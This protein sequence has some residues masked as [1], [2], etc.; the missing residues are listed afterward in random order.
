MQIF[1]NGA[2]GEIN[3]ATG[4]FT[5]DVVG[6]ITLNA[7]GSYVM[8]N[9]DTINF[10]QFYQNASGN[11]NIQ[12]PTQDKDIIFKGNDGG[13][14]ITALTLDMSDNGTAKFNSYLKVSSYE[15]ELAG[16]HLRFKF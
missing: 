15:T 14:T 16:G 4:S 10:A 8:F 6:N 2:N 12:A 11:L 13:S 5:L 7:D 1:H 9:D 3:V